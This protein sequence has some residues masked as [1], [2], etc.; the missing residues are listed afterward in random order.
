[1]PITT[2][3]SGTAK[4]L[5]SSGV[6]IGCNYSSADEQYICKFDDYYN[7]ESVVA[8]FLSAQSIE[9]GI[10]LRPFQ[11]RYAVAANVRAR[12]HPKSRRIWL[13]SLSWNPLDFGQL[14]RNTFGSE[15]VTKVTPHIDHMDDPDLWEPVLMRRPAPRR[16]GRPLAYYDGGFGGYAHSQVT[17]NLAGKRGPV[18]NSAFVPIAGAPGA[19]QNGSSWSLRVITASAPN[20]A[21]IFQYEWS[22]NSAEVHI[23]HKGLDFTVAKHCL[24]CTGITLGEQRVNNTHAWSIDIQFEERY[25]PDFPDIGGW[26]DM[27]L[28]S[29]F[30]ARAM[31]AAN[32]LDADE[33]PITRAKSRL[34][35]LLDD[36][37]RPISDPIPLN[38][39]GRELG[40]GAAV[41]YVKWRYPKEM[42]WSS[43]PYFS[44]ILA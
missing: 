38:G 8:W 36:R 2:I 18:V 27:F 43:F 24:C 28:D 37:D 32:D 30:D 4:L 41:R 26:V 29:G 11:G 17:A 1:M 19:I 22:T 33:K 21:G 35:K 40:A 25:N 31:L 12:R 42:N 20:Y 44:R 5:N 6:E 13:L 39:N 14:N 7:D 10:T 15:Q 34:R 3:T 9:L 23:E 16:D